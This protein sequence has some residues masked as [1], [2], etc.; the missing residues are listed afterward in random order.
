MNVFRKLMSLSLIFMMIAPSAH[1]KNN[2]SN[3]IVNQTFKRLRAFKTY[4]EAIAAFKSTAPET[5]KALEDHIRSKDALTVK[6]PEY[7]VKENT[8]F[9]GSEKKVKFTFLEDQTIAFTW[10][11]GQK[12]L[13]PAMSFQDLVIAIESLA[14]KTE[15]SSLHFFISDAY[16]MFDPVSVLAI[17]AVMLAVAVWAGY[18]DYKEKKFRERAQTYK[19]DCERGEGQTPEELA[20]TF[21]VVADFKKDSCPRRR[22]Y[23]ATGCEALDTALACLQR[24]IDAARL[25]NNSD[26]SQTKDIQFNAERNRYIITPRA[27]QQ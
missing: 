17:G 3:D 18:S 27:S 2:V 15:T 9:V 24:R 6:L 20:E 14:P 23:E 5:A 7:T 13:S 1:A 16:A 11:K 12:T 22:V 25:T 8:V 10:G 19:A 26:R 21:N 4:Q